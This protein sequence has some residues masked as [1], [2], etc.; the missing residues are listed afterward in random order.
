MMKLKH[1]LW[2]CLLMIMVTSQKSLSQQKQN[3]QRQTRVTIEGDKFFINGSPINEGQTWTTS[4]GG[5]YS[6][7]GLLLNAR[8]VQ[9][10]FD[11]LNKNTRGQWVYPD[12]REW[13][14]ERNTDEFIMAMASW[15]ENGL[16]GFTLNLQGGCPYGYCNSFSWDNSAFAPDGSLRDPFMQRAERILDKA[17]ELEMIVI[18][19]LFYFGEDGT[20]EDEAAVRQ[21]VS[22]AA[23][24][25]LEKG[26]THVVIEINNECSIAAYD[27]G[28][29]KCEQVHE[30]I[31]M[32]QDIEVEGRRLY[33][34]TSLAGGHVPTDNIVEVSDFILLHGNGVNDFNRIFQISE[35]V[36]K[37]GVYRTKPLVN[38]EDDIPWR[39]QQQGWGDK[40]NN[41]AA[42]IKSRTGWGYFDFRL[43]DEDTDYNLG[44]QSIPV[45][46]QISSER[47]RNFFTLLAAITGSPGTPSIN[48]D[49]SENIGEQ[50][51]VTIEGGPANIEIEKL[52]IIVN[53]IIVAQSSQLP[54]SF[55]MADFDTNIMEG[56]HW[57]KARLTYYNGGR[58]IIVESPYYKNPWWPYGGIRHDK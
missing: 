33:A 28:N 9:G 16:S 57:I 34:S 31:K 5:S 8:L 48:M 11:D 45:N 49:F 32:V 27:H 13:D 25:V 46:W 53:N 41:F 39:N 3:N 29:L 51:D 54:K 52:E 14:P 42:S 35:E 2:I 58:R 38:N 43:P 36:R 15:K 17:D 10:I 37:K 40:G 30:L 56:E 19:G 26:Y 24:W 12:T 23:S 44:F 1:F 21:A 4:Y 55:L 6:V 50:F 7:E 22:N 18:L 20:L 47:K